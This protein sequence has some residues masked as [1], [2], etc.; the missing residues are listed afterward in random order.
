MAIELP[1][2]H[3]VQEG[4]ILRLATDE[5]YAEYLGIIASIEG[6]VIVEEEAPD[7]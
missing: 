7:E 2:R 1:P 6:L 5:E 3:W 4:E